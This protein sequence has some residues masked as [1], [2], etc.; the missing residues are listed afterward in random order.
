MINSRT[1]FPVDIF[2][3]LSVV[4]IAPFMAGMLLWVQANVKQKYFGGKIRVS[5]QNGLK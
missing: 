5:G 1:F 3:S 4:K 2:S